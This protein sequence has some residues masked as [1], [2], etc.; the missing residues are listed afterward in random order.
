MR[1]FSGDA[2]YIHFKSFSLLS[3]TVLT[4]D[5]HCSILKA[6]IRK[7]AQLFAIDLLVRS[8]QFNLGVTIIKSDF[9]LK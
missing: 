4:G 2:L 8:G 9:K 7:Q 3:T 6:F 5:Y 1:A